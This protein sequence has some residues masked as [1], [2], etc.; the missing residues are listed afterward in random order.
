MDRCELFGYTAWSSNDPMVVDY[1][2]FVVPA[3]KAPGATHCECYDSE[4]I[5]GG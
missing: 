4:G 5:D 1:I 3:I 2:L